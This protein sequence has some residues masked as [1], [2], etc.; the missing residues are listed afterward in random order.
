MGKVTSMYEKFQELIAKSDSTD[1]KIL[2]EGDSWFKYPKKSIFS[3]PSNIIK[4]F[5]RVRLGNCM[6]LF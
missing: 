2:A 5:S 3:K 6:R 1:I 4:Q